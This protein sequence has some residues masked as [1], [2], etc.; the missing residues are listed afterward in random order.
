MLQ[1][2]LSHLPPMLCI[3]AAAFLQSITG[4]GLV[5]IAAPLLMLF[6][7]PKAVVLMMACLAFCSN[8]WQG[9]FVWRDAEKK[10]V[11]WLLAGTLVGQPLGFL[12]FKA[13]SP[14]GLK[15]VVGVFLLVSVVVMQWL[16]VRIA[17]CPRN[18]VVT[19]VASGLMAITTG[20]GGPPL[21]LYTAYSP[22]TALQLRA[23]CILFFLFSNVCSLATYFLGGTE[24]KAAFM[25]SL[26]LLPGIFAGIGCGHLVFKHISQKLFRRII[27]VM[28][29]GMCLQMVV[30]ALW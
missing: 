29:L 4:F 5:I 14:E 16:R 7:E 1:A 28:L 2:L 19:G 21:I 6:Y 10:T 9:M 11:F 12:V 22:L 15:L 25:E 20:M 27:L 8:F 17:L 23:T 26:W 18:S 13:I 3:F 30:T 24:L